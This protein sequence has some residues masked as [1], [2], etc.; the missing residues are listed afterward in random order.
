MV[1]GKDKV[2]KYHPFRNPNGRTPL[3][4]KQKTH[5]SIEASIYPDLIN[6]LMPLSTYF[7]NH[8]KSLKAVE[9]EKKFNL[10]SILIVIIGFVFIVLLT[11]ALLKT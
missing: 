2:H 5:Q 7:G 4:Q 3:W 10:A 1:F 8:E 6:Y 11:I 9:L